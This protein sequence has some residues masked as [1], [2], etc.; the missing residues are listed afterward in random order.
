MQSSAAI[1][2]P[3]ERWALLGERRASSPFNPEIP[4][5]CIVCDLEGYPSSIA[6]LN[7]SRALLICV[8]QAG[9]G[10]EARAVEVR[11]SAPGTTTHP[12]CVSHTPNSPDGQDLLVGLANGEVALLSLATLI[13]PRASPFAVPLARYNEHSSDAGGRCTAVCWVAGTAGSAFV[14]THGDGSVI[15]RRRL[16]GR[17]LDAGLLQRSNSQLSS[18]QVLSPALMLMGNRSSP[19]Q[20]VAAP[21]PKGTFIAVAGRDG[22]CIVYR[23]TSRHCVGKFRV[24]THLLLSIIKC[25]CIRLLYLFDAK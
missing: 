5:H 1:V 9:P 20:V 21:S 7:V 16:S 17:S 19:Q 10:G 11:G 12:S 6:V 8:L 23:T 15:I 3:E 4:T 22:N 25:S 13:A 2:T 14:S 24:R 18:S